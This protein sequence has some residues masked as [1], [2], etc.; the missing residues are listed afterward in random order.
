MEGTKY[1][2]Y[3]NDRRVKELEPAGMTEEEINAKMK[4]HPVPLYMAD[5]GIEG[6]PERLCVAGERRDG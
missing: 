4:F 5:R 2:K 3:I 6:R 1:G